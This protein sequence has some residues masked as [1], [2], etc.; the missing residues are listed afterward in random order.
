M[1]K[2]VKGNKEIIWSEMHVLQGLDPPNI[3]CSSFPPRFPP[4]CGRAAAPLF[5]LTCLVAF[6]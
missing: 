2:E 1:P 4:L 5:V 6:L 3:V